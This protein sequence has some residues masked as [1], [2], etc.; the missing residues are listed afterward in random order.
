MTTSALSDGFP[1]TPGA[2]TSTDG[3][4]I[5]YQTLGFGPGLIV[6]HGALSSGQDYLA[7]AN[8]LAGAFTVHLV[9][10][11][12]HGRS[13]PQG[14]DYCIS[15]EVE[16]IRAVQRQTGAEVL[17]GHSFGGLVALEA[18]RDNPGIRKLAVYEPGVSIA[19]SIPVDWMPAYADYLA[20]GR[21]L[22]AF[23]EFVVGMGPAMMK[24]LPRWLL[25]RMLRASLRGD[26]W[27]RMAPMLPAN[28]A[29]HREVA[30][31]D[32]SYQNYREIPAEAL[33]MAGARS[34]ERARRTLETLAQT[35]PSARA[36]LL[37]KL[38]HFGP[39]TESP[40]VV[41]QAVR[42]FLGR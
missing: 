30:R 15:R 22:D 25:T 14:A 4:S 18:A 41:A 26:S 39:T 38:N 3:V 23:V 17:F 29:E 10:R 7:F 35:M 16:D 37:P 36:Q 8:G 31:L 13:G 20:S 42:A 27:G 19:R 2:V 12:G 28:L 34:D 11:R 40:L 24:R 9:D 21:E 33:L 1:T 5:S 6:V 32:D